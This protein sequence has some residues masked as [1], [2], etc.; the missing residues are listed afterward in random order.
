MTIQLALLERAV[1]HFV[2]SD[3]S[4][5]G[6]DVHSRVPWKKISE[7]MRSRGSSYTFAPATCAKKYRDMHTS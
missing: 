3:G 7:W 5:K 2:G 1:S 4:A 6:R